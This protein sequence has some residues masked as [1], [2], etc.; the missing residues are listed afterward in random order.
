MIFKA[1][2]IFAIGLV[3]GQR[4]STQAALALYGQNRRTSSTLR[5]S[6]SAGRTSRPSLG[7]GVGSNFNALGISTECCRENEHLLRDLNSRIDKLNQEINRQNLDKVDLEKRLDV[8]DDR[9]GTLQGTM[10]VLENAISQ[11]DKNYD[12]LLIDIEQTV[13]DITS[14]GE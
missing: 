14:I 5:N 9:L 4:T 6:V 2:F 12:Q 7:L 8:L 11:L 1:I 3:S 13:G 10:R